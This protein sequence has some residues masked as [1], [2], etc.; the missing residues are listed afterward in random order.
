MD[1]VAVDVEERLATGSGR[2]DVPPQT[3]SNIVRPGMAELL[4]GGLL[5][6]AAASTDEPPRNG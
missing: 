2:D 5:V 1:Q 3:F 4:Y 6:A